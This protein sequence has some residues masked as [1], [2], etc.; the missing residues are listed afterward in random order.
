ML[1]C[2]ENHR[3]QDSRWCLAVNDISSKSPYK[4]VDVGLEVGEV[5]VSTIS[6]FSHGITNLFT[7]VLAHPLTY[8]LVTGNFLHSYVVVARG[9]DAFDLL[10]S[11][12]LLDGAA[13]VL[14]VVG[15]LV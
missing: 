7:V 5:L 4:A 8:K 14:A 13:T 12:R 1:I 11:Q 3:W 2:S 9:A 10:P 6:T 15:V